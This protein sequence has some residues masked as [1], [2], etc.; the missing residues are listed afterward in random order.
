M[1]HDH[2]IFVFF[3][4]LHICLIITKKNDIARKVQKIRDED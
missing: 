4:L 3:V 1:G 2:L